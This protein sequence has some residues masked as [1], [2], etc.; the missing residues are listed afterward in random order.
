MALAIY[1]I[2][3]LIFS[4]V[5]SVWLIRKFGTEPEP[6]FV[7]Y[8]VGSLLGILISLFWPFMLPVL[9]FALIIKAIDKWLDK[10]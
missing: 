7:D 6:E 2:V 4:I 10:V 3:G 5:T 8:I 9:V 1:L